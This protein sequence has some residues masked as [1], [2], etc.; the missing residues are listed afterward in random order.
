MGNN[1]Q[2]FKNPNVINL[3]PSDVTEHEMFEQETIKVLTTVALF[4]KKIVYHVITS[5]QDL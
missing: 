4:A 2:R 3:E 5:I 1:L